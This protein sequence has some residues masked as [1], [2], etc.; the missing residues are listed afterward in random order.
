MFVIK[1][2]G[3]LEDVLVSLNS[4]EYPINFMILSPMTNLGGH[5]S[6]LG[7][8]WLATTDAFISCRYSDMF[9]FM[10]IQLKSSHYIH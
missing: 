7:R 4:W 5:P 10:T 3:I 6:I 9:I 2:D 8:S 1:P